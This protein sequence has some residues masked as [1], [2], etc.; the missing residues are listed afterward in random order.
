MKEGRGPKARR[1]F[2]LFVAVMLRLRL[3]Y[4]RTPNDKISFLLIV[5]HSALASPSMVMCGSSDT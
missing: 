5:L 2:Y 4:L 1:S 3:L